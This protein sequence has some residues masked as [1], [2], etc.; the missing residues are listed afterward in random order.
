MWED[1]EEE[2]K[3]DVGHQL[4]RTAAA[5]PPTGPSVLDTDPEMVYVPAV[6]HAASQP[7][8]D[9]DALIIE[10][11]FEDTDFSANQSAVPAESRSSPTRGG[12]DMTVGGHPEKVKLVIPVED[13]Q[14]DDADTDDEAQ[15]DQNTENISTDS[16][17][18]ECST[19]TDFESLTLK[20][21]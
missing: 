7:R 11:Q 5:P 2:R 3:A 16:Q 1:A 9:R 10:G 4:V 14:F 13:G 17:N 20:G 18:G 12:G 21:S 6:L 15:S 19:C 8:L